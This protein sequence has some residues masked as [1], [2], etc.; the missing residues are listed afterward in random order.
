[1]KLR[2]LSL[3][4]ATFVIAGCSTTFNQEQPKEE[5]TP[6]VEPAQEQEQEGQKEE[7][8]Q[9]E[10]EHTPAETQ[11][12]PVEPDPVEPDPGEGGGETPVIVTQVI[13]F[14]VTS[15]SG[16]HD[17]DSLMAFMEGDLVASV[18]EVSK[19]YKSTGT[20]GAH[21][22]EDGILKLGTAKANGTFTLELKEAISKI[23]IKCHDFYAKSDDHP[24]NSNSIA[25]NGDEKLTPYNETGEGELLT[26]EFVEPVSSIALVA[27]KRVY[28]WEITLTK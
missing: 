15:G 6:I 12:D 13:S 1:M 8:Q 2:L 22:N 24:T 19:V 4:A 7:P 5:E 10:G 11:P 17:A 21:P 14:A 18:S 27:N 20:S 16:E 26:W 3:L 28:I 23:E 9:T 25:I